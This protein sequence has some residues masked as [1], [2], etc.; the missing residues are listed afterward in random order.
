MGDVDDKRDENEKLKAEIDEIK[1]EIE[2]EEQ[3]EE[4]DLEGIDDVIF[5]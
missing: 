3:E 5:D 2:A 1:K 4:S